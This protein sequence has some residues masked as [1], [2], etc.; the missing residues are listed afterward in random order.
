MSNTW[1]IAKKATAI[2]L[3]ILDER[4]RGDTKCVAVHAKSNIIIQGCRTC[5]VSLNIPK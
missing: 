3:R 2:A 1:G 4:G 5:T